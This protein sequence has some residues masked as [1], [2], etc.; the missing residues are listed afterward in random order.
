MDF[1]EVTAS[2]SMKG[3][4]SESLKSLRIRVI[5]DLLLTVTLVVI[6][7]LVSSSTS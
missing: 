5:A 6:C 3:N 2:V 1:D 4:L 7:A